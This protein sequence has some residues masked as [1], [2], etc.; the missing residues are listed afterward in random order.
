MTRATTTKLREVAATPTEQTPAAVQTTAVVVATG[1]DDGGQ[2]SRELAPAISYLRVSTKEQAQ[3]GGQDEGF[4]IPAQREA[5]ARKAGEIGARIVAEFI[6]AGE[7]ARSADRPDL[8]RMI[9]YVKTH[10][11]AYCIVHK[12]DRLARNRA[13]DVAIHLALQAAGVTL[14]SA[15]ENIDETPS[16]MLLHGIMST[17]AE[18]YS[19]NLA[20][21]VVKGLTQKAA[22]GGTPSK[23]PVGYLNVHVRNEQGRVVRTVQVDPDRAEL[24]RWAFQA[25]A[26]GNWTISQLHDELEARGLT[27]PPTPKRPAKPMSLSSL[28]RMLANPYYKGDVIYRGVKYAG[29]H[30]PLVP[31]EVWY[32]VQNVLMAHNTAGDRTQRHDHYLKGTLHCGSCGSRMMVSNAKSRSGDI[33][34]YYVCA[35]RH[36]KATPC[37]RSAVLLD[38]AERL[39]LD[40]YQRNIEVPAPIREHLRGMLAAEFDHLLATSEAELADLTT[41]RD[42]LEAEQ[43]KLLHA[44]YAD[45]I[46]LPA[47][48]REQ[49]RISG[50][51]EH[52]GSRIEIFHGDYAEARAELE[53]SLNLLGD[54]AGIYERGDDETR[55]L[56]NQAF[57]TK[58]YLDE[59]NEVRAD[60]AR[61]F[62]ILLDPDI[63]QRAQTW[64]DDPAAYAGSLSTREPVSLVPGL[65]FDDEVPRVGFEPTLHG[66]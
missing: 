13:D 65:N 22:T 47:L 59:D 24:V 39:V 25:Y 6:D 9:A 33:Y 35:G 52:V 38:D 16:G 66:F 58:L 53:D 28:H 60:L 8:Q 18:F 15:T 57:F 29:T 23:A 45:A 55:R 36:S 30:E 48:K 19:R 43:T 46:A 4:S 32:Q 1:A 34:P 10:R 42:Q 21:E 26:T 56:C 61:P 64:A 27:I 54:A 63:H 51:L 31:P 17:I 11:V 41:R 40:Y 12:I 20:T 14:V 3:K 49:D 37:T 62:A 50:E 2:V 7:S 44:Y 5:N